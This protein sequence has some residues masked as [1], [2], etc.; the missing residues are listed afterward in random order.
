MPRF[1]TALVPGARR[2]YTSWTFLVVPPDLAA[3]W[4]GGPLAV[5]GTIAGHPF[6]GTAT[7]GEGALR[8][9]VPRAL[10]DK[11]GLHRGDTVAVVLEPDTKP[12]QVIVPAELRAVFRD[13]PEAAALYEKLPP[14]H[15]RA[16]AAH[17]ADARRPETRMRRAR[18]APDGIR[19]RAF[20]R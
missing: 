1:R 12:R 20:P 15:R 9:P 10:R 11:V 6:R 8:V 13:D 18:K 7:K 4:G 16:W 19:A 2:P 17:V 14:A 5:R 3:R